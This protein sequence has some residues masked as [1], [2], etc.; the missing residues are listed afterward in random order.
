[1]YEDR[2]ENEYRGQEEGTSGE[3]FQPEEVEKPEKEKKSSL[4]FGSLGGERRDGLRGGRSSL[5]G[6]KGSGKPQQP[7]REDTEGEGGEV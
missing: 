1:M 3:K 7:T 2:G 6:D 5:P 4:F